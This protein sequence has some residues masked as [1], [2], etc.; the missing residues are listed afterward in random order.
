MSCGSREGKRFFAVKRGRCL[1]A[2]WLMA[3]AA[4]LISERPAAAQR[5]QTY[6]LRGQI[7]SLLDGLPLPGIRVKLKGTR[8]EAVT[9]SS[10]TFLIHK[11]PRGVYELVA[12]YPDFEATI[13]KNIEVPPRTRQSFVFTLNPETLRPPLPVSLDRLSDSLAVLEGVVSAVIDTFRSRY[14][15][16]WLM[17]KAV[18]AGKITESYLYP[19]R[20]KL[21][22]QPEN[23]Y[24]FQFVLPAG[25]VYH[26]FLLWQEEG[27]GFLKETILHVFRQNGRARRFDLTR[28]RRIGDI[29]ET[30]NLT[31]IGR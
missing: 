26:L 16:G 6:T 8:L 4:M 23:N 7:V 5:T 27:R 29:R 14:E 10:G 28:K 11:V 20:W 21:L 19:Q 25:K 3:V 17:L 12:K 15:K 13:L 2:L 9:D 31:K 18:V 1:C 24:R 22:P 30:V